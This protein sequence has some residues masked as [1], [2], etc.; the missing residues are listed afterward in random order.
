MRQMGRMLIVWCLFIWSGMIANPE[1]A[2][3]AHISEGEFAKWVEML[4]KKQYQEVRVALEAGV[5]KDPSN[6][7]AHFY[8][9]EACRGLK[10]WACAEEHYETSLE[11][12]AASTVAGSAKPPLLKAKVWQLLDEAKAWRLLNEAK[13]LITGGKASPDR[14]KQAEDNLDSANEM[15]LNDEQQTVY[16]QLLAKL[17]QRRSTASPNKLTRG[18][19]QA[20][21]LAEFNQSLVSLDPLPLDF[22]E[23]L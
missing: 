6:P 21:T 2:Q 12:D 16:Q 18:E 15:G 14:M 1:T 10:A 11:L 22:T 9:A 20:G 19:G 8:L 7:Q 3:A 23:S 5:K 17:S 13:D 4:K